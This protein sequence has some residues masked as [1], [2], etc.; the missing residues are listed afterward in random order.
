MYTLDEG[1]DY[2]FEDEEQLPY[3]HLK[4]PGSGHSGLVE[5]V[6]DCN[7]N[8]IFA[9]KTTQISFSWAKEVRIKVFRNEVALIRRLCVHHHFIRVFATYMT[10]DE[11]IL[12]LHPVAG[13][14]D[15]AKYLCL[16][17]TRMGLLATTCDT[18]QTEDM[19]RVLE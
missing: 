17:N 5:K 2:V 7:T 1:Q 14:G 4:K 18:L 8:R 11:I 19:Q 13:N 3:T 6:Q 16:Y 10:P 12:I 15:L 9:R